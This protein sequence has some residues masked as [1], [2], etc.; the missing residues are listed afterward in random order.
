MVSAAVHVQR[1]R[2]PHQAAG[3]YVNEMAR[4][5][6]LRLRLLSMPSYEVHELGCG[7]RQHALQHLQAI[8]LSQ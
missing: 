6:L 4:R 2:N 8:C 7:G 3:G 5:A 1:F